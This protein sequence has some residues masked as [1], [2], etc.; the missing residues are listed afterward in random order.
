MKKV[1]LEIFEKKT[2][3]VVHTIDT[4]DYKADKVMAGAK[5]N[6]DTEHYGIRIQK[7]KGK[8]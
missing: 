4:D 3:R 7:A 6:M 8:K 1:T 5:I 2:N